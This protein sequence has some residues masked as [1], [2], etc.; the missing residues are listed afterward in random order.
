MGSVTGLSQLRLTIVLSLVLVPLMALAVGAFARC[1][2]AVGRLGWVLV[3]AAAGVILG[4]THLVGENLSNA[5]NIALEVGAFVLV[6]LAARGGP[7]AGWSLGASVALLVAAAITHWVFLP[8]ALAVLGVTFLMAFRASLRRWSSGEAWWRTEAG[9]LLVLAVATT[10]I[11]VIVIAVVLQ[12][13]FKTIEIAPD[14]ILFRRKFRTDVARLFVPG[15]LGLIGI[16]WIPEVRMRASLPGPDGRRAALG[17]RL[18]TAWTWVMAAGIVVGAATTLIPPARFLAH[19]VAVSGA[20]TAGVVLAI[21]VGW[22]Q[23]GSFGRAAATR[24]SSWSAIAAATMVVVAL[25]AL[26]IPA[27]FRWYRYPLLMDRDTLA[28]ARAAGP[29]VDALPKGTPVLFLIDY[30]GAKPGVYGPILAQRTIQIAMDPSRALDVHIVPGTLEDALAGRITQAPSARA[31]REIRPLLDDA[32]AAL[33]LNP[34]ILVLRST[35]PAQFADATR[36]PGAR[37]LADGV[38]LVRGPPPSTAAIGV[39]PVGP[40]RPPSMWWGI[41]WA[42]AILA[43]LAAVG[44]G[45]TR[46]LLDPSAPRETVV[47]LVPVIGA[48]AVVVIGLV[49]DRSGIRLRGAAG[50]LVVVVAAGLGWVVA[51]VRRTATH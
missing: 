7:G 4:P 35:G 40:E 2:A 15:I 18:L 47:S 1:F 42:V 28:E 11:M 16:A 49:A 32:R 10:V 34:P 6:L 24:R 20:V 37:V 19:L 8:L 25:G 3:V 13:P 36:M 46:A 31:E 21:G 38:A 22:V 14:E 44:L 12:A 26:A 41:G 33:S 39:R 5:L 29:Y 23:R 9:L 50:V 27:A 48:A 17:L 45:W 43:V 51:V 30:E